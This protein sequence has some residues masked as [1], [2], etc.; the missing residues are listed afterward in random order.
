MIQEDLDIITKALHETLKSIDK[1]RDLAGIDKKL[2]DERI[3][4]QKESEE[5][6]KQKEINEKQIDDVKKREIYIN[7]KEKDLLSREAMVK[8]ESDVAHERRQ[9]L[10]II[11]KD[12]KAK[13][14]RVNQF[15]TM[16]R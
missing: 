3:L 6:K 1:I 10:D 2:E 9:Q 4:I 11:E 16:T 7:E 5:V 8:K 14:E 15:L 12:L 13:Q